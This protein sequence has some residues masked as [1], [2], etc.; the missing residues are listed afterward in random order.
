MVILLVYEEG[1][2]PVSLVA[3][4]RDSR[5]WFDLVESPDQRAESQA[6]ILQTL[7]Q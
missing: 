1:Q 6:L 3:H 2:K 4:G 7:V 5:T